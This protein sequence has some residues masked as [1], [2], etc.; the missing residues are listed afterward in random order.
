MTE[1]RFFVFDMS[2]LGLGLSTWEVRD[3]TTGTVAKLDGR[4]AMFAY[5]DEAE[6][7]LVRLRADA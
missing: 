6:E 7:A 4:S 3:R 5:Q 1:E 2:T